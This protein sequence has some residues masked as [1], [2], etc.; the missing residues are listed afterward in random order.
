MER[1]KIKRH[2]VTH[3]LHCKESEWVNEDDADQPKK[4]KREWVRKNGRKSRKKNK[5]SEYETKY[6][7]VR[8]SGMEL[9]SFGMKK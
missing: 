4:S 6:R 2:V 9:G 8:V 7:R 3:H 5:T 1:Q